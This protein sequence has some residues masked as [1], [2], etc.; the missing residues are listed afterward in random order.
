[1]PSVDNRFPDGSHQFVLQPNGALSAVQAA[2]FVW[3]TAIP[4]VAI[5]LFFTLRGFWPVLPFA[6]IEIGLLIWALRESMRDSRQREVILV[7]S[8]TVRI[9]RAERAGVLRREF[10]RHWARVAIR[11]PSSPRYPSR[12]VIESQGRSC[13][14]GRF[15]P[16]AERQAFAQQLRRA[17]GEMNSSP[18]LD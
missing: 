16:E 2:R 4:M 1:M 12:L 11:K 18:P 6:G 17:V 7:N 5:A 14:I 9:E 15:L 10:P 13:E 8:D 3:L